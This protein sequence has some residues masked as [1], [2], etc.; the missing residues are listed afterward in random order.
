M[1]EIWT[2]RSRYSRWLEIE[3]LAVEARAESGDVPPE[4][5]KL[6]KENAS[7]DVERAIEIEKI[8]ARCHRFSDKRIGKPWS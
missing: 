4:D 5:L 1:N 2:I 6:I 8:T 7:F 3:L